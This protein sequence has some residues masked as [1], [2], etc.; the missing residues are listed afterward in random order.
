MKNQ[1][2]F[3]YLKY[4]IINILVAALISI[5]MVRYVVSAYK[6]EGNSMNTML[7]NHERI[8][9]SKLVVKKGNLNR[10]DIIVFRKP[11]EPEKSIIKR[12]IGLPE[13]II[14]IK[15]GEVYINS[16]KLHQPFLLKEE[17][18]GSRDFKP[19]L[20][21]RRHYFLMGDNRKI[22]R[23]SRDFGEVPLNYIY[24][25]AFFRYWPLSR[26]GKIE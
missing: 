25:K 1:K 14:E 5:L 11:D 12:I 21:R 10:F 4:I 24:G 3:Q 8:L 9:I 13:E 23:D 17:N 18:K 6:I 22:S 7:K 26:F 15:D 2:L 20:I 19:L 16:I